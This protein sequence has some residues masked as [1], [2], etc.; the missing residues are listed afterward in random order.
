MNNE[1]RKVSEKEIVREK[2]YSPTMAR[3]RPIGPKAAQMRKNRLSKDLPVSA[4]MLNG[5]AVRIVSL[6]IRPDL[7]RFFQH[8]SLKF[9]LSHRA[10]VIGILNDALKREKQL[11]E[12]NSPDA[13]ND[14]SL[15]LVDGSAFEKISIA[16]DVEFYAW[17]KKR[18]NE[19]FIRRKCFVAKVL[20][21]AMIR[22]KE[23]IE[24]E[25]NFNA[26]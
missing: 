8:E 21:L 5:R 25:L 2:L 26:N 6:P 4:Y 24:Q 22:E 3:P 15:F 23:R 9:A 12:S 17:A 1:K 18:S 20:E 16:V 19:F 7:Y 10:R 11:V 13:L 14:E